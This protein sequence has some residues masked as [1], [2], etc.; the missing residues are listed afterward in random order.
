MSYY[1]EEAIQ[2]MNSELLMLQSKYSTL[3]IKT[4]AF[5]FQLSGERAREFL[6]QGVNRR[7]RILFRCVRSIFRLFPPDKVD[8]LDDDA[9]VDVQINLH[10]FLINVYGLTENLALAIAYENDLVGEKGD[11]KLDIRKV[12]LFRREF[13]KLLHPNLRSYLQDRK[14]VSWYNEY[15]KNYR[16]ALAHRVPPYVPPS[17]LDE[18]ERKQ[19][20]DIQK[21]LSQLSWEQDLDQAEFLQQQQQSLGRANPLFV[22]SFADESKPVYLHLQVIADFNT[23]EELL[24]LVL[25][26]FYCEGMV[27]TRISG[28]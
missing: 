16:D 27:K 4:F 28:T 2:Q 26:N 19:S 5:S 10:A 21:R 14:I 25:E 11:G 18:M 12:N 7:L 9:R 15:A 13:R 3:S 23:V 1:S 20:E 22:H 8:L 24:D 6:L 17:S